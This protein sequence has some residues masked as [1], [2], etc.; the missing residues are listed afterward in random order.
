MSTPFLAFAPSALLVAAL[1]LS[2][3]SCERGGAD[4]AV[5]DA[6]PSPNASILPAPIASAPKGDAPLGPP[7]PPRADGPAA[8]RGD[9][10]VGV[11]FDAQGRP[12]TPDAA[13][14]IVPEPLWGDQPVSADSIGPREMSGVSLVGEWRWTDTPPPPKAPEVHAEG[15]AAARR[16]TALKWVVTLTEAGR[17]RVLFDARAFPLP[18]GSELRARADR[19][20][21]VLLFPNGTEYRTV[22]PGGLR[23]L[24]GDR[25]LDVMPFVHGERA[26]KG[27]GPS[28]LGHATR[29]VELTTRVGTL[30]LELARVPEAGQGAALLCRAFA[31]MIG[32]DPATPACVRDELPLRA[33][34]AWPGGGG[35]A[36]EVQ[37]LS[38]RAEVPLVEVLCPP[39]AARFARGSMPPQSSGIFLTRDE[40]AALRT[41]AIDVGPPPAGAP[42]EGLLARNATDGLRYLLL[43]GVPLAWVLPRAEQYVIGPQRGRYVVQWRGFFGDHIEPARTVELPARVSVG[44]P[45]ATK[46]DGGAP[47][48][49]KSK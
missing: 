46:P 16:V 45:P 40:A 35:I 4:Q 44:E 47:A 15:L 5:V 38:R 24:F 17:M 34:L 25:R 27:N 19:Y 23:S 6:A 7:L 13:A 20:G 31:E 33:H 14:A 10:G 39:P 1:S 37:E 43:D 22:P 2:L 49:A 30:T 3:S 26:Q 28:R 29:R 32:L 42:G 8:P 12:V 48:P 18:L 41:R 21:H 36:F 11:L 9:G